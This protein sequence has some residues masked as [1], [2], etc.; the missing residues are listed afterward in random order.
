MT[1][2]ISDRQHADFSKVSGFGQFLSVDGRPL[3]TERGLGRHIAKIFK[4][5]IRS[6]AARSEPSTTVSVP[7]I[8]LHIR[9]PGGSYDANIEPAKDDVLFEDPQFVL[10]L[11]SDLFADTYGSL[12]D[13]SEQTIPRTG[14]VQKQQQQQQHN[15]PFDLLLARK[16]G[17][18]S[19]G[20][21]EKASN[22]NNNSYRLPEFSAPGL[23]FRSPVS[24]RNRT[25][26]IYRPRDEDE[27]VRDN[28]AHFEI[29]N[30]TTENSFL[31]P[32]SISK[33]NIP[34]LT[35][36]KSQS[37]AKGN[38]RLTMFNSRERQESRHRGSAASRQCIDSPILPSPASTTSPVSVDHSPLSVRF[39]PNVTTV[40]TQA[41]ERR[42]PTEVVE[43]GPGSNREL[44]SRFRAM[45]TATDMQ[46]SVEE[47]QSADRQTEPSLSQCAQDRF[48]LCR[49]RQPDTHD[50]ADLD[51]T[52][53]C[54]LSR[55]AMQQDE[56]PEP[57]PSSGTG[58]TRNPGLSGFLGFQKA[59]SVLHQSADAAEASEVEEALDFERRKRHAAA[60]Q[61]QKQR[62]YTRGLARFSA[63]DDQVPS[64]SPHNNRYLAARAALTSES[65]VPTEVENLSRSDKVLPT[66]TL[67][68]YDPRAYLIRMRDRT[69]LGEGGQLKR[70]QTR[71]L[72]FETI[73]QGSRLHNVCLTQEADQKLILTAFTETLKS[74]VYMQCSNDVDVSRP[75][76]ITSPWELGEHIESWNHRLSTLIRD[77]Y[78][79]P[80]NGNCQDEGR[81]DI[82]IDI[83]SALARHFS[84]S[85]TYMTTDKE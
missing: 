40:A 76:N 4:S 14:L 28:T 1:L 64:S 55:D 82:D 27:G 61:K 21:T 39:S 45:A 15:G 35:P 29:G 20:N 26:R 51:K 56:S 16:R 72:P 77:K 47:G 18:G 22:N 25:E 30:T 80:D 13:S 81:E 68:V 66:S 24:V 33:M 84:D 10:S 48:V 8:C 12:D 46:T 11:V 2:L 34:L 32:W 67:N 60:V 70:T 85:N 54:D 41:S 17:A 73:P 31:N 74:D 3:S 78:G 36:E 23:Q 52:Q 83:S 65:N 7:F 59:T 75:E 69:A 58:E 6:A 57:G 42:A 19:D 37:Q 44:G 63:N 53:S 9:C 79:V 38:E 49:P 50:N 62:E 71:R 5:Y 43:R